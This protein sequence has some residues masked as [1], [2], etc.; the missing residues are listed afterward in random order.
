VN[1]EI[2]DVRDW[3]GSVFYDADCSFCARW[4]NRCRRLL[5]RNGF[6]LV[7]LQSREA[8][9]TLTVLETD[10]LAEMRVR[11]ADG[12]VLGGADAL[13]HLAKVVGWGWPLAALASLPGMKSVLRRVYQFVARHR[14]CG[15]GSCPATPTDISAKLERRPPARHEHVDLEPRRAGGRRSD[16]A[17]FAWLPLALLTVSTVVWGI[18]LAAW[19]YMW[20][21]AGALFVGCKWMTFRAAQHPDASFGRIV[22]F[23]F[24][25]PGMN[26][27]E[28][29]SAQTVQRP[30]FDAWALAASKV[31]LGSVLIWG[32]ARWCYPSNAIA[33]GWV[34][35]IGL[36]FVL[37][38]GLFDFLSLTWRTAGVNARPIMQAPILSQSPAEFWGRRWNTGFHY[39]SNRFLFRPLRRRVGL[40]AATMLVFVVSGLVHELVISVPARG[41]YGWP[42]AYFVLQGAGV[43]FEH[44]GFARVHGVGRGWKGWLFTVVVTA[45]PAFC[46]FHPPF[47]LNVIIP[48][49]K[50]LGAL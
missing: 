3:R 26:A 1:T 41:G 44:T 10:L 13:V 5:E 43:L 18:R 33:A 14:A 16:V 4:A 20:A 21:I 49:L 48:F 46:L 7:P 17:R 22:G 27:E 28:F 2:T 35:L 8:R 30:R 38:F 50:T 42:T 23:L 45:A 6:A 19:K 34:G 25:W 47:I 36:V 39:L 11:T 40:G 37:H 24:G 9:L 15:T 12:L 29:F 32:I 31:L